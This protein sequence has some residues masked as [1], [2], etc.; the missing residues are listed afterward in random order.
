MF[1]AKVGALRDLKLRKVRLLHWDPDVCKHRQHL[2]TAACGNAAALLLRADREKHMQVI[3]IPQCRMAGV[4]TLDEIDCPCLCMHRRA[5]LLR[6]CSKDGQI[7]VELTGK[8]AGRG[9]Y[10]CPTEECLKKAVKTRALERAFSQKIEPEVFDRLAAQ[11]EH[12][13]TEP[14]NSAEE[15]RE[16]VPDS[17]NSSANNKEG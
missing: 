8:A 17:P 5:Q 4:R 15:K 1:P 9:A 13:K 12:S 7:S 6:V 10:V 3:K 11:V 14:Q 16:A 2:F